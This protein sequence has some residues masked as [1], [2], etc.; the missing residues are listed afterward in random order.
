MGRPSVEYLD[1]RRERKPASGG[2]NYAKGQ[3]RRAAVAARQ[4]DAEL[5]A[6][7][8]EIAA[9]W[10]DV[11][12]IRA[13]LAAE[14]AAVRRNVTGD[15]TASPRAAPLWEPRADG[16]QDDGRADSDSDT[17]D[18]DGSGSADDDL[19]ATLLKKKQADVLIELAD[20]AYLFHTP[21]GD[22]YADITKADHRETYRVR[23]KPFRSWLAH[24]FYEAI[25]GAPNSG[26]MQSALGVIEARALF[27]GPEI[28]VHV[29]VA[30][31]AGKIY[32]DLADQKWRAVE[33][34][35]SGWRVISS[36]PV[37]FRRASG[38]L[39]LPEPVSG[40]SINA[41][42]PLIN[43]RKGK[44]G[45]AD[46]VLVVAWLL[47][48][49]RDV[50]PY[51]VL[52]LSGEQ[53]AAKSMMCRL[54]RA[55]IDPNTAPLRALPREDRD[56]F[57]AANNGHVLCFDN[58]S[59]MPPWISD[60]L[61]RLATGGGFSVRQLYTDDSEMLFDA[62]RPAILNGIE[63]VAT[64]P[65]LADRAILLTLEPIP[66]DNR[67]SERKLWAAFDKE[68]PRILGALLDAM[69]YGLK[70]LPHVR[71]DHLP[72]MAD[73]AVWIAACEP[74]LWK[75]GTFAEAYESNRDAAVATTIEADLV[76]SA[77]LALMD[78]VDTSWAG[79][80]TQLL[81]A[82]AAH[83]PETQR[84]GKGWPA[85]PNLL[86]GRLRRMAP[87]MRKIGIMIE[88]DRE[89]DRKRSRTIQIRKTRPESWRNSSPASC[90]PSMPDDI[91]GLQRTI[92]DKPSSAPSSDDQ[93]PPLADNDADDEG[94]DTV[95]HNPLKTKAADDADDKDDH[96]RP[97][98]AER[99]GAPNAMASPTVKSVCRKSATSRCGCTT[100]VCASTLETRNCPRE[101]RTKLPPGQRR[102]GADH[103]DDGRGDH[104]AADLCARRCRRARRGWRHEHRYRS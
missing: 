4:R 86:T 20:A 77:L 85:Q 24:G 68:H 48:A 73:F 31:H 13:D 99:H 97:Y 55:L 87:A 12:R 1:A 58:V 35:A 95:L 33:I 43:V 50:G 92:T 10:A 39:A 2:K 61:C 96:L 9:A 34:D 69:A 29:R 52:G 46:F 101:A 51:P 49:L 41:L 53:G 40:G 91:K 22:A 8:R 42:R 18:S 59:G 3:S 71:L 57:I 62:M 67:R 27:D 65:D 45:D 98:S 102:S 94:R 79:T 5:S 66:E 83:V 78:T 103:P 56:L 32:L 84:R 104:G 82:L 16:G 64:R 81:D 47:A 14:L 11:T 100:N 21:T 72:R 37:R 26:A 60:T 30:G 74:T 7:E 36:P 93:G 75:A 44:D 80:A 54:L 28:A 89:P 38:M 88:S 17:S 70:W 90:S 19:G 15:V 6:H 76:A 63:D 25:N 23:S